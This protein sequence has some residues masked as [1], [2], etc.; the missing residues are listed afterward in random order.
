M[1]E[2]GYDSQQKSENHFTPIEKLERK[3]LDKDILILDSIILDSCSFGDFNK[4]GISK[5]LNRVAKGYK[6]RN[7]R[8]NS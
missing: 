4:P 5:V 3:A 6:P 1:K 7:R 2:Y 8:Y